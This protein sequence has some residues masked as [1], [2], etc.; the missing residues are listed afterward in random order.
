MFE[1]DFRRVYGVVFRILLY[2][3]ATV[4]LLFVGTVGGNFHNDHYSLN[5]MYSCGRLI[6]NTA[7][8]QHSDAEDQSQD[9]YSALLGCFFVAQLTFLF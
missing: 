5:V 7:Q 8:A 4:Y 9:V 2:G 1:A 6:R 3:E